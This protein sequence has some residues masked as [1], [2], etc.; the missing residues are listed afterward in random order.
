MATPINPGTELDFDQPLNTTPDFSSLHVF[1]TDDITATYSG[2]T[3]GVS[4]DVIDFTGASGTKVTKEGVTLYPIDSEFGFIVTD[5]EGAEDKVLNDDYAE[6]WAGD[7]I[8]GGEQAGLVISDSPTDTFKT[9]AVLGTWLA[10]LGGNSVKA[11]TEHYSVM[12]NVLSDQQFPD[13]PD[14]VYTLD[15]NLILL[16]QNAAWDGQYVADLLADAGTYGI[17]DVN[18]DGVLD[19]KDLLNPNESTIAYDIAYGDDYSVTMKD[20]G[21]LLYRWGNEIKRP[22]DVRIEAQLDTPDEWKEV[23]EATGLRKLYTVSAAELVTHHTITNNPNDQVRPEDFENESAIGTLPTYEIIED[24]NGEVGRTVWASTDPYYAGDGTLYEAGTILRDSAL[25][26]SYEGSTLDL[27]GAGSADLEGG[28]TNAWYT[29]MDREPFEPVLNEDGTEYVTGPRWRLLPDKYGQDLPGVVIPED[30]SAPLPTLSADVKY[31]VGAETQTVL[32]L[33]DWATDISPLDIS[34]GWQDN[35]GSVSV[36]GLNLTDDF[37]VAFYIKGDIKPATIYSTE[38]LLDHEEIAIN[39]ADTVVEGGADDDHLVG[40]GSNEFTGGEGSDLF[41]LSYGTSV[42][43]IYRPS[44]VK[45]FE[46]GA[47]KLGFIGIDALVDFDAEV[48][49]GYSMFSQGVSG[50]DLTLSLNGELIAVLEGVAADL[51]VG[52][53]V[54][55]G[56]GLN[57]LNDLFVTNPSASTTPAPANV[58]FGS[59]AAEATAGTTGA[60]YIY[61]LAGDDTLSGGT[62][63][64]TLRGGSGADVLDGGDD[65]DAADYSGSQGWVNV[66]LESGFVGGGAGSHAIGDTFQSI[67]GLVGSVFADRLNGDDVANDIIGGN[68]DDI[69]RGRGGADFLDGGIGMDTADYQ[70]SDGFVNV[71]LLTG[72]VGGGAGS[73]AIGDTFKS[74]EGLNGSRFADILNGDNNDNVLQGR[75]GAD[76]LN[77]NGGSDTATYKDS[78]GFV[79]VSLITGYAGGGTGSHA[80]G[81]VFNSIENLCGSAFND[82]M[83]G[84]HGV[85]ILNGGVGN[86]SMR[87]HGG[88]DVFVFD[89]NFGQDTVLDF[90]NGIEFLDFT[91]NSQ[92]NGFADLTIGTAGADATVADAYGNSIL[93]TAAAGLIDE[94]DFLFA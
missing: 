72:Y 38:L 11:S 84:D 63:D 58:I 34:A 68:G 83:A 22:N 29:T 79:N 91:G 43:D 94:A 62:G 2:V 56:E 40:V 61:G 6:G 18:L 46:V 32:N 75:L 89:T 26:D 19:I 54:D 48:P 88:A 70:D 39:L 51:G 9:P 37:D 42:S 28:F 82:L 8:I 92:V 20:D 31:E 21:K 85:N 87:G 4:G 30:P 77:G 10:G 60:D 33:L 47:D 5:F 7:L 74:I 13:D 93:L 76:V 3:Q 81:D 69:L 78:A 1:S 44:T 45:D 73:D 55:P 27:I 17:T 65:M 57:M 41:V 36:N 49:A 35:A 59:D 90:Q 80:I 50:D 86:D 12:Q 15:D 16:S 52:A 25:V 67:E 53:T 64:D 14:A 24:Y 66:S 23:D 71:S